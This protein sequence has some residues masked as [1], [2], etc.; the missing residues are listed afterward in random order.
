MTTFAGKVVLVTGASSGIGAATAVAFSEQGASVILVGRNVDRLNAVQGQC[1]TGDHLAIVA[2]VLDHSQL[3]MV[4]EKTISK[5]KRLDVLVNNAG[6]GKNGSVEEITIDDFDWTI[7]L[8]VKSVLKLTQLAIPHLKAT[9]GNIVNVGSVAGLNAYSGYVAYCVSKAALDQLTKCCSL[10]LARHGV[11]V[12]SVN[13]AVVVTEFHKTMG[14]SEEDYA[15]FIAR[16]GDAYPI[17]RV[18]KPED[19]ADAI[20]YLAKDTSGFVTGTLFAIS[21]GKHIDFSR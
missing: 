1:K 3:E 21:G 2:D 6:A 16:C 19:V 12:N 4:I 17:G 14:M 10:D 11:R 5:Y 18:G 8:N 15:K 13:P 9:K 20:L 7:N